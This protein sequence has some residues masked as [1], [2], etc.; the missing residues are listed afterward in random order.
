[1]GDTEESLVYNNLSIQL[2][3]QT[4][5]TYLFIDWIAMVLSRNESLWFVASLFGILSL[6]SETS[7]KRTS[8]LQL[9][10]SLKPASCLSK[11]ESPKTCLYVVFFLFLSVQLGGTSTRTT[12]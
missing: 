8:C 2:G 3:K 11:F 1:M 4:N 12:L 5:K 6:L 10:S 7:F 9:S